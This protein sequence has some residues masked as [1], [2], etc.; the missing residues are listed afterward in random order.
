M[1][2]GGRPPLEV[3][4]LGEGGGDRPIPGTQVTQTPKKIGGGEDDGQFL[5]ELR[6]KYLW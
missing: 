2:R 3:A 5:Y 1:L 6:L 4:Q